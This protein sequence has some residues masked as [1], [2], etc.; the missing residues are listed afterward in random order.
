[1]TVRDATPR[2]FDAIVRL[3]L[4]SEH[5]MSRMTRE[6]LDVLASQAA[7]LRVAEVDG[8]VAAFLLAF[9]PGSAYDSENY[10]WFAARY[11]DFV[12][13]DRIAVDERHR[14]R[15]L[16]ALLYEDLF[17]F[18][19]SRG[20]ARVVCEFDVDPPNPVSARFHARFGFREVGSQRVSY[21]DKRV[22]MQESPMHPP[23]IARWH[24]L[25]A[26]RN[27]R[28]LADLIA[29]D[30]VFHSPVVHTPQAGKAK[31]CMYLGAAFE[32]FY[33]PT[34]RYVR[35][36]VGPRDAV[37]EFELTVDG[38]YVNGVDMIRWNEAGQVVDFKVLLRPLQGVNVIHQ[39][40]AAMLQAQAQQQ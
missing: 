32:V 28:G 23:A 14:G 40:M 27:V 16:G 21:A 2:D 19:R 25:L 10:R 7:Y 9:A 13:I 31:T 12:Y 35:E 20:S 29:P 24:E 1:M 26:T 3:N 6:R 4:E 22:S 5:F 18:A 37:L 8:E 15:R 11:A 30:C 33:N 34:F 36:V 38:T 39:K 17:A